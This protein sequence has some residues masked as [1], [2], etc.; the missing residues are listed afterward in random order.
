MRRPW[1][2]RNSFLGPALVQSEGPSPYAIAVLGVSIGNL[3]YSNVTLR[4]ESFDSQSA[5]QTDM[6][7]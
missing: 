3:L 5:I 4:F 7:I 6:A 2:W 1:S